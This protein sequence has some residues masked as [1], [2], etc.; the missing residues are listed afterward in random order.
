MAHGNDKRKAIARFNYATSVDDHALLTTIVT[1]LK[2][3]GSYNKGLLKSITSMFGGKTAPE[4][5]GYEINRMLKIMGNEP[6]G[7]FKDDELYILDY[8]KYERLVTGSS[9]ALNIQL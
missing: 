3:Q 8:E 5:C 6:Q 9:A 2:E 7:K 4:L 1:E